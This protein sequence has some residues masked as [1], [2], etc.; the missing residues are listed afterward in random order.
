MKVNGVD[1]NVEYVA[2]L[3]KE[4]FLNNPAFAHLWTELGV[5]EMKLRLTQVWEMCRSEEEKPT[6]VHLAEPFTQEQANRNWEKIVEKLNEEDT[7]LA[8]LAKPAGL[9]TIENTDNELEEVETVKVSSSETAFQI[10]AKNIVYMTTSKSDGTKT[11]GNS[12]V[13]KATGNPLQV[14]MPPIEETPKGSRVSITNIKKQ[15]VHI[16]GRGEVIILKP[17]ETYTDPPQ[18]DETE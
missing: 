9:T 3:P 4:D 18:K 10:P 17:G 14:T 5:T 13:L 7:E 12:V 6:E 15:D 8:T 1:F 11:V 16:Y 2:A